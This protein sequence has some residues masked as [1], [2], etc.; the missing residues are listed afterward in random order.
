MGKGI[1]RG[2]YK[3]E[4]FE[5]KDVKKNT[6][7]GFLQILFVVLTHE[8][9]TKPPEITP[10]KEYSSDL[11]FLRGNSRSLINVS[12]L[13]L[14]KFGILVALLASKFYALAANIKR[15]L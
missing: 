4:E 3:V 14:F 8:R 13:I 10:A 11:I 5:Q 15:L 6:N 7:G 2:P 9:R 12:K 1:Q